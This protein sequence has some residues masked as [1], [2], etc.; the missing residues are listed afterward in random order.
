MFNLTRRYRKHTLS[1]LHKKISS[2]LRLLGG[3]PFRKGAV[4]AGRYRIG[5]WLGSGSYGVAYLAEDLRHG[6][7]CVV[8]RVWPL[9]GGSLRADLIYSMETDMLRRS[10]HPAFPVI[11]ESFLWRGQRCFTMEFMP[12]TSLDALLFRDERKFTESQ[13]LRII[14]QLLDL[15]IILH[16]EGIIHRD[17]SIANVLLDG[18]TVKLIDFGLAR[19]IPVSGDLLAEPPAWEELDALDDDPSEKKFRRA[20]HVS[21]DFYAIGH[22]LL[23]LLYSTYAMEDAGPDSSAAIAESDP[24]RGWEHELELHPATKK[25]LRRLLMTE[26]PFLNAEEICTCVDDILPLLPAAD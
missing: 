13:S 6:R 1:I 14:R 8:K 2:A 25:L 15:V 21:S 20:L 18:D 12:G 10:S 9:R 16:G 3:I 22:L 23:F 7:E 11:Y 26:Q 24:S 4:I 5:R 19:E 17:I